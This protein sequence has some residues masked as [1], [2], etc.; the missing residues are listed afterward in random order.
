[1]RNFILSLSFL[2]ISSLFALPSG[3]SVQQG[4]AAISNPSGT[5]MGVAIGAS[6]TVI[7]WNSYSVAS[8]ETVA[9]TNNSTTPYVVWNLVKTTGGASTLAGSINAGSNGT[10]CIVNPNGIN[11]TGIIYAA[12][13]LL[14]TLTPNSYD[15]NSNIVFSGTTIQGVTNSGTITAVNG[16]VVL[17][18]Y[19]VNNT[20]TGTLQA[21]N[22]VGMA[23]GASVLLKPT[24][25]DKLFISTAVSPTTGSG[26]GVEN[27]GVI[28]ALNAKLTADGNPYAL[29][30][31]HASG[32]S[33]QANGCTNTVDGN[34]YLVAASGTNGS[35]NV[36]GSITRT[37]TAGV[38]PDV[39]IVGYQVALLNGS[40]IN[41]SGD[42]GG[43]DIVIGSASYTYNTS[44]LTTNNV[45]IAP[46]A[47]VATSGGT[48]G[49][50]GTI[51][52]YGA[53]SA[54]VLGTLNA[55]GG[56]T[57]GNGGSLVGT[58]PGYHGFGGSLNVG[59]IAGTPGVATLTANNW[60]IAS[61]GNWGTSCFQPTS[62]SSCPITSTITASALNTALSTSNTSLRASGTGGNGNITVNSNVAWSTPNI[63]FTMN[64]NNILQTNALV[65]ATGSSTLGT[66]V[67]NLF[68]KDIY[69][70]ASDFSAT[71][72]Y[73][74]DVTSG[75][76]GIIATGDLGVFGGSASN[77]TGEISTANGNLIGSVGGDIL[78]QSGPATGADAWLGATNILS[79][80]GSTGL[81]GDIYVVG[82]DCSAAYID[83]TGGIINIGTNYSPMNINIL[84]SCCASN[85]VTYIGSLTGPSAINID[86]VG[87]ITVVAGDTG[88]GNSAGIFSAEGVSS[89]FDIS[90][91]NITLTGGPGS[92]GSGNVAFI[93]NY[94]QGTVNLDVTVDMI[95]T[96]GTGGSSGAAAKF[97][98][99]DIN[100][101]IGRDLKLVSGNGPMNQTL[102]QGV[103][104]ITL[105]VS[106]DLD[107]LSGQA[108]LS[109]ATIMVDSG[110]IAIDNSG[111]FGLVG[112][113]TIASN[114]QGENNAASS[115]RIGGDGNI[116]IRGF[117]DTVLAA[118]GAGSSSFATIE[119]MGD[120]NLLLSTIRDFK[121]TGG[122]NGGSTFAGVA[123]HG[124]GF[125]SVFAG[126]D[127]QLLT[128]NNPAA[129]VFL[130]ARNGPIRT[131]ALR[132]ITLIGSCQIPNTAYIATYGPNADLDIDSG[133]DITLL[134]KSFLILDGSK[135]YNVREGGKL[136]ISGCSGIIGGP[137][138]ATPYY[139]VPAN[140]M[141][142]F[143][144][145]NTF[146]YYDWY[147][148]SSD[149]FWLRA[150]YTD[151]P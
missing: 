58:S 11:N 110:D 43:G 68:G 122:R 128:G 95:L 69:V 29:A 45:Y 24:G 46:L 124:R 141:E 9:Y 3:G 123:S 30:I 1:M 145:V 70:G 119:I 55:T 53:A 107:I 4:S 146:V 80:D 92:S 151:G 150:N 86:I 79:L 28:K 129:N 72:P 60:S 106:R 26:T 5:E 39:N 12:G 49:N 61:T 130:L 83:G 137:T 87:D 63:N 25:T 147:L 91:R 136:S 36:S 2:S 125:A 96:G 109:S 121:A 144:R 73:G 34:I 59:A 142:L 19:R 117:R 76:I 118:G 133:R 6:T 93:S 94:T 143:W 17:I 65:T 18:G 113:L 88:M 149:N 132:D 67:V 44:T 138:S 97:Y 27:A 23:A 37:T 101:T 105:S 64:G 139:P 85:N 82:N 90:A 99:Y 50:G 48:G 126:N 112:D 42:A 77:A 22:F 78:I 40:N 21:S 35:I 71:T 131:R 47:T 66:Q 51:S 14:S 84:G 20:S 31:N 74:F 32:G 54:L 38:G 75:S 10:I 103:N 102:I 62:W 104:G 56:T 111:G 120:G 135:N 115:I 41:V 57:A 148:L 81:P 16:D 89:D 13:C 8:N 52:Y 33:I 100:G 15:L 134:G 108:L 98:G 114:F 127:I 140:V 116:T 7:Q